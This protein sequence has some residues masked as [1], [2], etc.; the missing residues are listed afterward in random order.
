MWFPVLPEFVRSLLDLVFSS[1]AK[2]K[3]YIE[4][5]QLKAAPPACYSA[6]I[7]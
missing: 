4:Y 7:A 6:T 1:M 2:E 3:D 5:I